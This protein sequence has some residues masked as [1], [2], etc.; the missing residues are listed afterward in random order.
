MACKHS[1]SAGHN[2]SDKSTTDSPL[3]SLLN[4]TFL[5]GSCKYPFRTKITASNSCNKLLEINKGVFPGMTSTRIQ[6]VPAYGSRRACFAFKVPSLPNLKVTFELD[7]L[8]LA[9]QLASS[10]FKISGTRWLPTTVRL[11]PV[12]R[13]PSVP[14]VAIKAT[15][16][17]LGEAIPFC[18]VASFP[19][20]LLKISRSGTIPE[21]RA[22]HR[23][24]FLAHINNLPELNLQVDC[25]LPPC[26]VLA[27]P[28]R[29]C[30]CQH[31]HPPPCSTR[32]LAAKSGEPLTAQTMR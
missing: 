10:P 12:S 22:G 25:C 21:V 17:N 16:S 19:D 20:V 18:T 8:T 11:A 7:F 24:C 4:A 32:L 3:G 30:T 26:V 31:R 27:C 29:W 2:S 6:V 9:R 13:T 1:S 15:S 28:L 23:L 5:S 14:V